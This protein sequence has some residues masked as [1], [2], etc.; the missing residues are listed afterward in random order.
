M[1]NILNN[2]RLLNKYGFCAK[3]FGKKMY[4]KTKNYVQKTIYLCKLY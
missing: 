4:R 2:D 3:I 1:T